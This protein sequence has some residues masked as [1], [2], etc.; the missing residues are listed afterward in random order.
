MGESVTNLRIPPSSELD[1]AISQVL[2]SRTFSRS[3]QL[4]RLLAHLGEA[5]RTQDSSQL[6]ET[7]IGVHFFGRKDFNPKL[8]TIVRAEML[9][10]RRK[11]EEFYATE[12]ADAPLRV[13]FERN[14][15]RPM[16]ISPA[17]APVPAPAAPASP[18][19]AL[20]AAPVTVEGNG[21]A[22]RFWLG[23]AAGAVVVVLLW[24]A[25]SW[26]LAAS[27]SPSS[28]VASHPIWRG[29]RD[30]KVQVLLPAPLFWRTEHGFSRDFR[31]NLPSD[32]DQAE[33]LLPRWPATPAW[34]LWTPMDTAV[35]TPSLESFLARLGS[36]TTFQSARAISAAGLAGQRTIILGPPRMSPL[37][38]DLLADQDFRPSP[39][40]PTGNYGGFINASPQAGARQV[41]SSGESTFLQSSD[42]SMADYG[43]ITSLHQADGGEVLSAFGDRVQTS[44]Y[45]ARKLMEPETLTA[46]DAHL[47][48]TAWTRAQIV[49]RVD[50]NRGTPIGLA[51]V[52]HRVH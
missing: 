4:R 24:L 35:S 29:F 33:Q 41:Y 21:A 6:T 49:V 48:H 47:P 9:R 16:L 32:L 39:R 51:Y 8:D 30:T 1:A 14:S 12:A 27:S 25:T 22:R 15:Y 11:L 46:L 40:Q 26:W 31:L 45:L 2:A 28:Q 19:D 37:L 3:E 42:E 13:A 17:V 18:L 44:G 34:N 20:A 50:Y 36:Q 10:L 52:T 5:A 23:F 43:L 38:L 7:A